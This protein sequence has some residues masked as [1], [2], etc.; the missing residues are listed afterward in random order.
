MAARSS[1]R[2]PPSSLRP[3]VGDA[4]RQCLRGGTVG[5]AGLGAVPEPAEHDGEQELGEA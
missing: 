5:A 4:Q 2:R 3:L 1:T